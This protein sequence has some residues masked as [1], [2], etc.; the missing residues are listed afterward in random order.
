M[1]PLSLRLLGTA[2]LL[3]SA[4]AGHA[5]P[6]PAVTPPVPAL[7]AASQ[8]TAPLVPAPPAA[9]QRTPSAIPIMRALPRTAEELHKLRI[10][11][12][13]V[14]QPTRP[15]AVSGL[16]RLAFAVDRAAATTAVDLNGDGRL[17]LFV[18]GVVT[19]SPT[20]NLVLLAT[21]DGTFAADTAHPLAAVTGVMAAAWA[22]LNRDGRTDVFLAR[23]GPNQVWLQTA[24][25]EWAET[26][27]TV[28]GNYHSVDAVL[29]DADQDGDLDVFVVNGDGPNE[30][31][32]N[33]GDGTFRTL[34]AGLE[35]AGTGRGSRTAVALDLDRDHDVDLLVLNE[36]PPHGV[37]LNSGSGDYQP[38]RGYETLAATPA[39]TALAADL[40]GDGLPEVYTVH[41]QG[42][43]YRWLPEDG[44]F[45][46]EVLARLEDEGPWAQLAVVDTDGNGALELL[47]AR[48][49]GWQI[50]GA[51]G[52]TLMETQAPEEDPL[53]GAL[54]WPADP[55]HGPSVLSLG[56]P[57][58]LAVSAP[59]PGR[60]P[61]LAIELSGVID[62]SQALRSDPSGIGARV[63]VEVDGRRASLEPHRAHSGPG[64]GL[65][66]RVVGLGE[67][68]RAVFVAI[69]WPDGVSQHET[70]LGPG[71]VHRVME[72]RRKPPVQ[73]EGESE[74]K[75]EKRGE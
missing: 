75:T 36:E 17:D 40:N 39:L 68:G 29:L 18:P 61:F 32:A 74:P 1:T 12:G 5:E 57:I 35:A 27:E 30:L 15:L 38:A 7:P 2:T 56:G 11:P 4:L 63:S 19:G 53:A 62:P 6:P 72:T 31:L 67:A 14:F 3:I 58:P 45:R 9:V 66:P 60:Y 73:K 48:P 21:A 25:G 43:V 64:Q 8:E 22:D 54:A 26:G 24:T 28:G 41:P 34:A 70:D 52:K 13:P 46:A 69:E 47:L 49:G 55:A 37:Y 23:R 59:G 10:P 65:T 51:S 20:R 33:Q 50:L 44:D 16:P 42:N 71:T